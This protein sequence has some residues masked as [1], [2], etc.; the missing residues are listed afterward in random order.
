MEEKRL[1]QQLF[2]AGVI[3]AGGVRALAQAIKVP[4]PNIVLIRRGESVPNAVA[5]LKLIR[6]LGTDLLQISGALAVQDI[7]RTANGARQTPRPVAL[8]A[9]S[10][11]AEEPAPYKS[12]AP[13]KRP[14][15]A[16]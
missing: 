7:V 10:A 5:L 8:D 16:P 12:R 15:G 11:V 1:I 13:R 6:F 9:E 14:R 4:H 2:E 3:R